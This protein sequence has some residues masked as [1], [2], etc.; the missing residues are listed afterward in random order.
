MVTYLDILNDA[1]AE[2][3]KS[4]I[5]I[6]GIQNN[7][8]DSLLGIRNINRCLAKIYKAGVDFDF[9]EKVADVTTISG[10][11][12]LTAPS[13]PN[14]WDTNIINSIWYESSAQRYKMIPLSGKAD[15]DTLQFN[16]DLNTSSDNYP[17]WWY[18]FNQVVYIVPEPTAAYT[19]KV[20]YQGLLPTVSSGTMTSTVT[21]PPDFI[22]AMRIGVK[23]YLRE[24]DRDPEWGALE[25]QF[26]AD[27]KLS[28]E[29]NKF[30]KK[31]SGLQEYRLRRS[32]SAR[33]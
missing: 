23:A 15:A 25:G 3:A 5:T 18:V 31:N 20:Y 30:S 9:A 6:T 26:I 19:L 33:L 28:M 1:R 13:S 11:N 16:I 29:R 2:V 22:E 10:S 21:M 14:Q 4:P 12:V 17:K 8:A 7:S 24:G 27:I 32:A